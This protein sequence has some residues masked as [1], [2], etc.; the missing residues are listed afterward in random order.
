MKKVQ[1]FDLAKAMAGKSI[2]T[3]TGNKAFFIAYVPEANEACRVIYRNHHGEIVTTDTN[4]ICNSLSNS[5]SDSL[6]M[7]PVETITLWQN[8][9]PANNTQQGFVAGDLYFTEADAIR[10]ACS[11]NRENAQQVSFTVEK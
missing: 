9:Y 1:H 3:F 8:I 6:L 11:R 7:A 5:P 10:F 4:G 2:Q